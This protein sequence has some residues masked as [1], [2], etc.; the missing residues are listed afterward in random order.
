MNETTS[1][2][3]GRVDP[4]PTGQLG[5]DGPTALAQRELL[6]ELEPG[7]TTGSGEAAEPPADRHVDLAAAHASPAL[8]AIRDHLLVALAFASGIY[9][10]ICFL[11][12]GKV[13]TAFQTGNI[14]FLGL[15]LAG[16]R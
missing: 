7:L 6:D 5:A 3:I 13:F 16:T 2:N 12:F 11:S 4:P 8:L 15:G 9:E 1:S 14:V 10:A